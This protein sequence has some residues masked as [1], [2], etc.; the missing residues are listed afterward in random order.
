MIDDIAAFAAWIA[1]SV[2]LL[3]G[4]FPKWLIEW[5]R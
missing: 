3:F 4:N 2:A 1:T 5:I